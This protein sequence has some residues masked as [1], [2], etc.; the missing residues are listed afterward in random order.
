MSSFS[1]LFKSKQ[2]LLQ[3]IADLADAA[4]PMPFDTREDQK[5]ERTS[6]IQVPVGS[7]SVDT[8]VYVLPLAFYL[9]GSVL[10]DCKSLYSF[11]SAENIVDSFC[12]IDHDSLVKVSAVA[13]IFFP[14]NLNYV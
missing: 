6:Y 11:N 9:S 14:P 4:L 12:P 3:P 5:S 8:S 13:I 10:F 1:V 2:R 7:N